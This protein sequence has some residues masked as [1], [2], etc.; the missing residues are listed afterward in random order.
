VGDFTVDDCQS[1]Q[2]LKWPV[3]IF[4]SLLDYRSQDNTLI[5]VLGISTPQYSAARRRC[6]YIIQS[7]IRS[8]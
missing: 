8:M 4:V 5:S 3:T 2:S 7:V 1:V 6:V